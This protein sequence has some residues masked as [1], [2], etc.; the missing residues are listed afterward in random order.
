[1]PRQYV[2]P[3]GLNLHH[4]KVIGSGQFGT[5]TA[6]K[7]RKGDL[8][9]LKEVRVATADETAKA[10][11][12]R[13]VNTM[14]AICRGH[15][16]I[17]LFFESW[18][19]KNRMYILMEYCPNGSL[20]HIIRTFAAEK[21][22]FTTAK[23][24]HYVGELASALD[25]CHN[26]V[27]VVHRDFKPANILLDQLGTIKLADFGLSKALDS[28]QKYCKTHV[29]TPY[30]MDPEQ[31][32][33]KPY[34]DAADVWALGVVA[35]ELM[36]LASPWAVPGERDLSYP[37]L[38]ARINAASPDYSKL[39]SLYS[40]HLIDT[41][42]WMLRASATKRA[43]AKNI[44]EFLSIGPPP[45]AHPAPPLCVH[46][47]LPTPPPPPPPRAVDKTIPSA[48]TRGTHKIS[49]LKTVLDRPQAGDTT[50]TTQTTSP[51]QIAPC[52]SSTMDELQ[53]EHL[54]DKS[55]PFPFYAVPPPPPP[56][57]HA[58]RPGVCVQPSA[59]EKL[60]TTLDRQQLILNDAVR[61]IQRSFRASK[62]CG[63][64]ANPVA[65]KKPTTPSP[66]SPV[67]K[68]L[69][70]PTAP[71]PVAVLQRAF[72]TSL[73]RRRRA[74][75]TPPAGTCPK[76]IQQLAL[77][78]TTKHLVPRRF[79]SNHPPANRPPAPPPLISPRPAW[80]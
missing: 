76:R 52:L 43:T 19:E 17:V 48:V 72:R 24:V 57:Y 6:V 42:K 53:R 41:T 55:L 21:K 29:G 63:I 68:D 74:L 65:R 44:V 32:Q 10:L 34:T 59:L 14:K 50:V 18:F 49:R 70:K 11:V 64:P 38:V 20:D 9:C 26:V 27:S 61:M 66:V 39:V 22:R 25:Y 4:E 67:E 3:K 69:E 45:C 31:I 13:E 5:A 56:S 47:P 46:A 15:P 2:T 28:N 12:V 78:R 62:K 33:G 8:F 37:V 16:N 1:M 73:N 54:H 71:P 51:A 7:N 30:Y 23:V 75:P 40:P 77:P 79:P 60:E 58:E 35:Y 36:A 80:T